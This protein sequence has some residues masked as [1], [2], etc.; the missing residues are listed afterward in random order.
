MWC[1]GRYTLE[2]SSPGI[3][4]RLRRPDHF[5]RYVGKRVRVRTIERH[6]GRRSFVGRSAAVENE[7]IV[8]EIDEGEQFIPFDDIAQANYEHEFAGGVVGRK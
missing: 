7:G 5:R 8:V 6:D 4:R 2:V 3:N 1:P